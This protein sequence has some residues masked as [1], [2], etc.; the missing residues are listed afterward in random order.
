MDE[1][2]KRQLFE[3]FGYPAEFMRLSSSMF[4]EMSAAREARGLG[5][6]PCAVR[7]AKTALAYGEQRDELDRRY[8][9][10]KW[11]HWYDRDIIYPCR[12][13]TEKLRKSLKGR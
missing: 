4:A 3:R 5:D 6:R 2:E 10:G 12:S 1:L 11:E 7:H 13:V 8:N 9:T